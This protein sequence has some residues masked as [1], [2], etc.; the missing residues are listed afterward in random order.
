MPRGLVLPQP[1]LPPRPFTPFHPHPLREEAEAAHRRGMIKW[2]RR[3]WGRFFLDLL[4]TP[5]PLHLFAFSFS[6]HPLLLSSS[7]SVGFLLFQPSNPP[8]WKHRHHFLL[9]HSVIKGLLLRKGREKRSEIHDPHF[10]SFF[11]FLQSPFLILHPPT[12]LNQPPSKPSS[13]LFATFA[14]KTTL[15]AK[16]TQGSRKKRKIDKVVEKECRVWCNK[17]FITK[18]II[19]FQVLF[20][21]L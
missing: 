8:P 19:I 7:S 17:S 13:K 16:C 18:V 14:C 3:Q 1:S 21:I 5:T 6:P 9:F 2:R 10:C 11:F 4:H 20:F 15:L 12:E